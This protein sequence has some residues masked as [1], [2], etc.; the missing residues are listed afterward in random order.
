MR[1]GV[2]APMGQ[3][4]HGVDARRDPSAD[5]EPGQVGAHRS[6]M[7]NGTW[8]LFVFSG[9]DDGDRAAVGQR[10]C[11]GIACLPAAQRIEHGAVQHD[12][13]LVY[14]NDG[15]SALKQVGIFP[16]QFFSHVAL[17]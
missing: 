9:V 8:V 2:K 13:R 10:Q 5:Y 17:Q 14:C 11:A 1:G 3:A 6:D 15:G 7:R 16:E 4:T 12:A